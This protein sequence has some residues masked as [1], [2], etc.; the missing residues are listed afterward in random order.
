V[1]VKMP[2]GRSLTTLIRV[3]ERWLSN[4]IWFR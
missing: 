1:K 3:D 2:N 4:T